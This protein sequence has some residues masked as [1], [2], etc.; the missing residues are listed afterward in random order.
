MRMRM[1]R[2][3]KGKPQLRKQVKTSTAKYRVFFAGSLLLL[4]S[5]Y[6]AFGSSPV[7]D[8]QHGVQHSRR[9]S[10][11][12]CTDATAGQG[13]GHA[14]GWLAAT[15]Y[16]FLGL[17]IVCDDWFVPSLEKISEELSLSPDVAGAT[18]LAAGSSAPEL[19]TSL[20]D[21]FG[22]GNSIGIGTIVGSAMFNILVIVAMAAAATTE[23]LDIDWRPVVR[24]CSFYGVS[25]ALMILFFNDGIIVWWEAMIMVL[26]YALYILFM[27]FNEKIFKMCE[28]K[29][30]PEEVTFKP[31]RRQSIHHH[32]GMF[33]GKIDRVDKEGNVLS[34]TEAEAIVDAEEDGAKDIEK[35]AE[36]KGDE[37]K[38]G[39]DDDD[40]DDAGDYFSY[41]RYPKDDGIYDKVMWVLSQPFYALFLLIPNCGKEGYE[42]FY[43]VTF[44]MSIGMIGGLCHFMVQFATYIGC[45]LQIDPIVMGIVVLAVGTSVPDALGSMIVARAGEA[46]MAIAN[47]VGSNV[48]DILLGL[49]FPWM[50]YGFIPSFAL[51][52]D[53]QKQLSPEFGGFIVNNCGIVVSVII[54]FAT[55]GLFFLTLVLFRWKMTNKV[56]IVF[57]TLYVLYI[58]W[59]IFSKTVFKDQLT[60]PC[61]SVLDLFES[62]ATA[63]APTN[64][65]SR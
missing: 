17:A 49:G 21:T 62:T 26:C 64:S 41:F 37:K 35:Q 39:D 48:F 58:I 10:G 34:A 38:E 27:V 29:V 55:L 32:K 54:L 36:D 61:D 8:A 20:A 15:L 47:A 28:K 6:V 33:Q 31:G 42:K 12:G 60:P 46:D 25:I 2:L 7:D 22:P 1:K 56:G 63:P 52:N 30:I 5:L 11:G 65:S 18:F 3:T 4:Y 23:V 40:D 14:I 53:V 19:F 13:I 43:V 50:I 45:I 16:L 59:T 57:V 9:L 24:D 44:V 51:S